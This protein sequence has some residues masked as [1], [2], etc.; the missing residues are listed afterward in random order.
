MTPDAAALYFT[1]YGDLRLE[2]R[3]LLKRCVPV[4]EFQ[5]V[6]RRTGSVRW[7]G[8]CPSL[9]DAQSAAILEARRFATVSAD[10]T[11]QWTRGPA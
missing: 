5:I 7:T 11:P 2:V 9:P 8:N 4:F 6:D 3:K 1:D 10:F